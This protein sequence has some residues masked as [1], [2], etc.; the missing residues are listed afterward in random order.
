MISIAPTLT[1][2]GKSLIIRGM[3]SETITFTRFKVGDGELEG[4]DPAELSDLINTLVAFGIDSIDT[5]NEGFIELTGHFDNSGLSSDFR[6]RELGIF[7]KGEDDV[8]WLYAYAN[9][10]DNA[11]TIRKAQTD[12]IVEQTVTLIVA[13][14]SAESVDAIVTPSN[15]Y[16]SKADFDAHVANV[17]NPHSVTKEQVGLGNVPNVSTNNQTPTWSASNTYNDITSGQT[18]SA[19]LAR[20]QK[21]AT[22]L[23][24]HVNSTGNPHMMTPAQIGAA[25]ARHEHSAY[26][27]TSDELRVAYGGTGASNAEDARA[28]LGACS[29]SDYTV[30]VPT[31][32]WTGDTAP[33][34]MQLNVTGIQ[35]TDKPFADAVQTGDWATDVAIREAWN[36][37]TQITTS[38]DAITLTAEDIPATAFTLQLRCFR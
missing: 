17:S 29:L 25:T 7:A 21:A 16:A 20:T 1:D 31:T 11:G 4:R 37:I 8:E 15:L 13:V 28:N 6:W 12:V 5:S 19:I 33:Y 24:S 26:E 18:L 36:C 2:A 27:I 32:G 14:G 23:Y 38:A 35:A 34:T 9:D 10:G 30:S 22:T 3:D